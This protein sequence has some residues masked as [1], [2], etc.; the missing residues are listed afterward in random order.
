[1][2]DDI[3][4]FLLDEPLLSFESVVQVEAPKYG[5]EIMLPGILEKFDMPQ[6]YQA[7]SPRPITLLNPH[8]GDSTFA[9]KSDLEKT[10]KIVSKTYKGI[11]KSK[12]WHIE[13][14]NDQERREIIF[15]NLTDN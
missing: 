12:E 5:T 4:E 8:L 10:D 2:S 14:V 6:V 3:S 13:Q 15:T 9:G 11:K 1:L 7:L